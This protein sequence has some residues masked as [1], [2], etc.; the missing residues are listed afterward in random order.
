MGVDIG[1]VGGEVAALEDVLFGAFGVED[2]GE[3]VVGGVDGDAE[4]LRGGPLAAWVEVGEEEVLSADAGVA[5]GGEVEEGVVAEQGEDFFAW[6]V[7][8]GGEV[9]GAAEVVGDG[10]AGGAPEV[11][12]AESAG[13]VGGEVEGEAVAADGWVEVA[14]GGVAEVDVGGFGP[15]AGCGS[16]GG[17]FFGLFGFGALLF[18]GGFLFGGG[19]FLGF[20][21]L[22]EGLGGAAGGVDAAVDGLVGA[23]VAAGE[24]DGVAVGREGGLAFVDGGV[25]AAALV[26]GF[27]GGGPL[28]VAVLVDEVDVGEGLVGPGVFVVALAFG[29]ACG[30]EDHFVGV[31]AEEAWCEVVVVGAPAVHAAD[32]VA[33]AVVVELVGE[34][35]GLLALAGVGVGGFEGEVFVVV[36]VGLVELFFEA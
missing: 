3:L 2:D 16:F 13:E 30:G 19:L 1:A 5:V 28:A 24:V 17:G 32:G 23:D 15:L 14:V 25:D 34:D 6:G 31:G 20:F 36:L 4:V 22:V 35:E 11:I 33:G 8:D 29:E 21:L 7:D 9:G 10:L 12:A 18:L 26:P 27:G